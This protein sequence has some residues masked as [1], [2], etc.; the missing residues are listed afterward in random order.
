MP[1]KMSKTGN[2]GHTLSEKKI[3][4]PSDHCFDLTVVFVW[5]KRN[6]GADQYTPIPSPADSTS[7]GGNSS[8]SDASLVATHGTMNGA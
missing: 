7:R 6:L 4:T 1:P 5:H 3:I 2:V 8:D